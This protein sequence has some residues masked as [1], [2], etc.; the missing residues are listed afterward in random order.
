[1]WAL[2]GALVQGPYAFC[3]REPKDNIKEAGGQQNKMEKD[4]CDE[5]FLRDS[6]QIIHC[7]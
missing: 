6:D 2:L 1:M 7:I 3:F 5:D 4:K